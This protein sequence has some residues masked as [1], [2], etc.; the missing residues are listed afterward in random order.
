MANNTQSADFIYDNLMIETSVIKAAQISGVR[1][2]LFLGSNAVYPKMS[3]QPIK[4]EYLLTGPLEETNEPYSIAKIAGI[5]MCQA[6]NKQ[7]GTNFI[8]VMSANLYG[9]DDHFG[10]NNSHVIPALI[11]K[12][13][14]A[15]ISNSKT[16]EVWGTGR[17]RRG[18]LYSDDLAEALVFLMNHYN[19]SE[20]I[21]VGSGKDLT[22]KELAYLIK[23]VV[24]F[25]GKIVFDKTKPDGAP[26]KVF[27]VSKINK[28]GWRAKTELKDGIKKE[29]DYFVKNIRILLPVCFVGL[30]GISTIVLHIG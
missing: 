18:F 9:P 6:F 26:Q 30:V 5:K 20:I 2:L 15:E 19:S 29:Y 8:S 25:R 1:K 4:E 13:H 12:F 16:V 27:D 23:D 14:E 28:L 21:N 24:G 7:Y 3:P 22:I 17:A 10:L 11:R